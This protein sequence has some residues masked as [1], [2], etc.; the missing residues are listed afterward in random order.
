MLFGKK[1]VRSIEIVSLEKLTLRISG[2]R[3]TR[4]YEILD[5]DNKAEISLYYMKCVPGGMEPELEKRA[6]AG[7]P[8]VTA[9]LNSLGVG[10]WDGFVGHHPKNV[11]D[12]EMFELRAEV[13]GGESIYAHGS[14][15]FPKH[16]H[17]LVRALDALLSGES[18]NKE[19]DNDNS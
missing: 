14:E 12:G 11:R 9:L 7:M 15:N 1:P 2:M 4:V 8:E 16:Y 17:E 10:S 18:R 13:N 6:Y 5:T 19:D 3:L